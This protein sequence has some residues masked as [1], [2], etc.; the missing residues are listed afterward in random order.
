[1]CA[2][3]PSRAP[4]A[5]ASSSCTRAGSRSAASSGPHAFLP[6]LPGA[7][8]LPRSRGASYPT[9]PG[10]VR[11]GA[12]ARRLRPSRARLRALALDRRTCSAGR[13]RFVL[14]T[15]ISA[16]KRSLPSWKDP[17]GSLDVLQTVL[18]ELPAADSA[19]TAVARDEDLAAVPRR[20][21]PR[22]KVDVLAD[23]AL[24]GDEG[25]PRC[26]PTRTW[27]GPPRAS[28]SRSPRPPRPRP[29]RVGNA[30]K[31]ASP[32]VSTSTPPCA[33]HAPRTTR[34]CASSAPRSSRRRARAA[35]AS[36]P[37][38]P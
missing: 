7:R 3:R 25:R 11:G 12:G 23:V 10:P 4:S 14:E 2:A 19:S 26:A 24:G 20:G 33:R 13:G 17:H 31:N 22:G 15:V 34:R 27:I 35:A 6:R 21:D 18:A 29:S 9:P 30:R 5:A 16:G 1:M 37:R 32:C 36:S 38:R 28:P 8:G